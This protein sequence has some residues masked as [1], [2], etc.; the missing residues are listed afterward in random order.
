[1]AM[2]WVY[3]ALYGFGSSGGPFRSQGSLEPDISFAVPVIKYFLD[4][5]FTSA[6]T[7]VVHDERNGA[8]LYASGSRAV[9]YMLATQTWGPPIALAGAASACVAINGAGEIATGSTLYTLDTAGGSPPGGYFLLSP[10]F[11]AEGRIITL[12]TFRAQTRHSMTLDLLRD[13]SGV[14]IGGKFPLSF[15]APH[16]TPKVQKINRRVRSVALRVS[17]TG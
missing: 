14:S 5:G 17:G 2:C 11:G 12:H 10:Y 9:P 15:I 1:N 16:G 8:V 3:D 7:F 13:L 6:N 4:N